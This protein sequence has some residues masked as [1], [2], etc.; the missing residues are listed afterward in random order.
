MAHR[1]EEQQEAEL[2]LLS[3]DESASSHDYEDLESNRKYEQT[4]A[5]APEPTEYQ[6]P[7]SLKFLWVTAYFGFSM[8][9]TIYN[10]FILG[11]VRMSAAREIVTIC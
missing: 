9:L 11:S 7:T 5:S 1:S 6:T 8:S 3:G 4:N 10:K 2:A